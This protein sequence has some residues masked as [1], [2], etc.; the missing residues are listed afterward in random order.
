[1]RLCF[2]LTLPLMSLSLAAAAAQGSDPFEITVKAF[3][4]AGAPLGEQTAT[5]SP[6]KPCRFSWPVESNN[7]FK[8]VTLIVKE[9]RPG[10]LQATAMHGLAS[11]S[12]RLPDKPGASATLAAV[13]SSPTAA[14]I[15]LMKFEIER[16]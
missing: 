5:C 9:S 13:K 14:D 3:T 11:P 10:Y 4:P 7:Q 8:T 16:H 6:A 15:V 2:F 12:V 1:M